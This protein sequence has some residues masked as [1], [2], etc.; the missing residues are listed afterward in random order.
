MA[1]FADLNPEADLRREQP[2]IHSPPEP[3]RPNPP[4]LNHRADV[5]T[6]KLSL[7]AINLDA[8]SGETRY[9]SEQLQD[10]A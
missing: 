4:H 6:T 8:W 3:P 2:M 5:K 9:I 1:R 10:A 7:H